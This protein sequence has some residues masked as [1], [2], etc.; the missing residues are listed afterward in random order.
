MNRIAAMLVGLSLVVG[1][2]KEAPE[3]TAS[4]IPSA[5]KLTED[6]KSQAG[7]IVAGGRAPKWQIAVKGGKTAQ[8]EV[9][10]SITAGNNLTVAG[11][12]LSKNPQDGATK[13][14]LTL[15]VGKSDPPLIQMLNVGFEDGS[16][17]NAKDVKIDIKDG[18]SK[19]LDVRLSGKLTCEGDIV[20][21][22][23]FAKA[24]P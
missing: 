5:D 9:M 23:G 4:A 1:C 15:S 7:K 14:K 8:G 16:T 18:A 19:T 11:K 17:C 12:A 21:F 10:T 2:D 22:S 6:A 20:E 13:A 24:K 3:D